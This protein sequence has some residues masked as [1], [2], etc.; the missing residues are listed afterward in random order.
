[1]LYKIK[2]NTKTPLSQTT[3]NIKARENRKAIKDWK[4]EKGNNSL[5]PKSPRVYSTNP[6]AIKARL[7]RQAL[8]SLQSDTKPM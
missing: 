5:L 6:R 8:K 7:A 4:L 1:M 3:K 2:F